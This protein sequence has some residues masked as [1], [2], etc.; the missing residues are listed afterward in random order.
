MAEDKIKYLEELRD[1]L[2]KSNIREF[3]NW[4]KLCELFSWKIT[5]GTYKL[6]REKE[7]SIICKWE[8]IGNKIKIK[9]I[10]NNIQESDIKDGRKLAVSD[11]NLD[12]QTGIM[13]LIAMNPTSMGNCVYLNKGNTF[14]N[15][16]LINENYYIGRL[17][18]GKYAQYQEVPVE[19]VYEF[20]NIYEKNATRVFESALKQLNQKCLVTWTPV[21]M[22]VRNIPLSEY[23]GVSAK[24][25][26]TTW[27]DE[28]GVEHEQSR[29]DE[30]IVA[31]EPMELTK[32]EEEMYL[33][34]KNKVLEKMGYSSERQVI[35]C[36]K[37]NQ[38]YREV[39]KE[40]RKLPMF[41][42]LK[43][44]YKAYK[45]IFH[46]DDILNELDKLG[47]EGLKEELMFLS[48]TINT[49][50]SK[51]DIE[52]ANKRKSK[53][54]EKTKYREEENFIF[55]YTKA[56]NGVILRNQ[57]NI[58]DGILKTNLKPTTEEYMDLC[59]EI[60]GANDGLPF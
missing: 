12:I 26:T 53:V 41:S 46:R 40:C 60:F 52:N 55:D 38:F 42:N 45:L 15:L 27:T 2:E 48:N 20:Y 13:L 33:H 24:V 5:R 44:I 34:C 49:K 21:N 10:N 6:A 57:S 8:K 28:Y 56:Q 43:K 29:L 39:Y 9:K 11:K 23:L 17:Y 36:H 30:R 37:T 1:K 54:T 59:E 19:V 58:I 4:T 18:Q 7:L 3:K 47:L 22:I 35:L 31:S 51:D 16:G 14:L 50:M 25:I 32:E